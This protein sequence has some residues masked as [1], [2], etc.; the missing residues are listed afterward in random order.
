M[1][2]LARQWHRYDRMLG[3]LG[4]R[5][6]DAARPASGERVLDVGCA[7]GGTSL[8]AAHRVRPR[9]AVVGLDCDPDAI[10]VAIARAREQ[11]LEGVSFATVAP[12]CGE[13][14]AG[15]TDVVVSRF[16]TARFADDETGWSQLATSLSPGGRLAVVCWRRP[17]ENP[18]FS[19]PRYVLAETRG[20]DAA[21]VLSTSVQGARAFDLAERET[22]EHTLERS[23]FDE[24][25]V[26]PLDTDVW[27]G[28]DVEEALE[29]FFET[30]GRRLDTI[31]DGRAFVELTS[32]LRSALAAHVRDDGVRLGAAAWLVTARRAQSS[33]PTSIGKR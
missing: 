11:R 7:T 12:G 32:A 23:G 2:P 8:Q 28:D 6:L 4:Q 31:L 17:R 30:E 1:T 22:I 20:V 25:N 24:W 33:T 14:P 16:G 21:R 19:L 9:G 3:A 15:A 29:F 26:E 27:M 13:L 10:R 5:A 18:W